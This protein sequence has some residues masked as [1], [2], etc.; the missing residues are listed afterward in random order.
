MLRGYLDASRRDDQGLL[1]VAVY[2]F[3]SS[4]V[5]RF[6]QC[7]R[8]TFGE[9]QFSWADLVARSGPFKSLRG[10]QFKDEHRRLM[11]EGVQAVREHVVGGAVVSCWSQDVKALGPTWIKG[12][13][14][15]YSVAGH[16][17]LASMGL[18]AEENNYRGGIAYV[19]EA[20]DEGYDELN[21]L[22]SYA[23]KS[24]DA[25]RLYQWAGHSV[26]PK[27]PAAPFHAPDLLAWEWGKFMI[28]TGIERKRPIRLS[29]VHLLE[30]R[31]D[32][33]AFRHLSGEPLVRFF[34]QIHE[35]GIEQLQEDR[36]AAV[37]VAPVDLHRSVTSSGS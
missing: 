3:E 6:R 23:P 13:G 10:D 20:G 4:R 19:I 9:A 16:L 37:S 15:A 24:S 31:L 22:L 25:R 27:T 5:R 18:W 11:A 12:F 1:S 34:R 2:L 8:E 36:A 29:L 28:D 17:A 21:H 30:G 35:L 14:H 7:W 33:Y 26:A 32:R